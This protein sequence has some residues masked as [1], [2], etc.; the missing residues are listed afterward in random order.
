MCTCFNLAVCL[1]QKAWSDHHFKTLSY[2]ISVSSIHSF[3]LFNG[4]IKTVNRQFPSSLSRSEEKYQ[5][6]GQVNDKKHGSFKPNLDCQQALA[7]AIT[8][9]TINLIQMYQQ[10]FQPEHNIA[11]LA[12]KLDFQ[13]KKSRKMQFTSRFFFT[14]YSTQTIPKRFKTNC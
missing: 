2:Y 9:A 1:A 12:I 7:V 14:I 8:E 4:R 10:L 13:K 5:T 6:K 3:Q 11:D